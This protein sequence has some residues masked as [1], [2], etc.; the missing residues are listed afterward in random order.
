MSF[1]EW[2]SNFIFEMKY[3]QSKTAVYS[4]GIFRACLM[5]IFMCLQFGMLVKQG[6]M[7][8]F[9]DG[10]YGEHVYNICF[11]RNSVKLLPS[12][13]VLVN[14]MLFAISRSFSECSKVDFE[15]NQRW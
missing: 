8:T 14:M 4:A 12:C 10:G 1:Q 13:M 5:A 15:F 3:K 7:S 6:W 11:S 2:F 9:R